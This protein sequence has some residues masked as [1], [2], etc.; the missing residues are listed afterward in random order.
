M[1]G[2]IA[3]DCAGKII[4]NVSAIRMSVYFMEALY[5]I[6]IIIIDYL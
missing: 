6:V 2:D 1:V 5:N 3:N 4:L